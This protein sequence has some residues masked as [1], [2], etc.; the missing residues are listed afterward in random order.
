MRRPHFGFSQWSLFQDA[1]GSGGDVAMASLYSY[2]S[3]ML[4]RLARRVPL[5]VSDA[6]RLLRYAM[7][8]L[9]IAGLHHPERGEHAGTLRLT[10][11][12]SPTGDALESRY[13]VTPV[14]AQALQERTRAFR[15]ALRRLGA[16]PLQTV[17]LKR[18][19]SIHY[20]GTL[21]FT[22]REAPLTLQP[23]GRL[24]AT[25]HV[26]VADASGFRFLPAKGPTLSLMAFADVV[27]RGWL[28]R[29]A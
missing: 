9:T 7:P 11:A 4:F 27:A 22:E 14:R 8:A 24:G 17:S 18:G 25:K 1:D 16:W 20:A 6:W 2:R 3:L 23:D 5:A 26:Y 12:S 29:H 28:D 10:P 19:A 13:P 21:P 15:W